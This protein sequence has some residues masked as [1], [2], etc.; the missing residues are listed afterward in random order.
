MHYIHLF[1]TA[2]AA[3]CYYICHS[4]KHMYFAQF[5]FW[6][7]FKQRRQG[8]FSSFQQLQVIPLILRHIYLELMKQSTLRMGYLETGCD[9]TERRIIQEL[10][11]EMPL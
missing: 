8:D 11:E 9:R 1:Q 10:Q 7:T 5:H 2:H 4:S 6:I 3:I